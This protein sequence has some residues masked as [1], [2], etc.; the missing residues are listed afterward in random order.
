MIIE[1]ILNLIKTVLFGCF[2]WINL[3]AFPETLQESVNTFLD[4]IFE[5]VNFLGF[6]VRPSTISILIPLI[7]IIVNFDHIY[8]FTIFILKKI[9]MLGIK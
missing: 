2:S 4:L 8:K 3:P 6:L 9:P 7:I 5:G 1:A